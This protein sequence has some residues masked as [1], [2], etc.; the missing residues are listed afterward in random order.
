MFTSTDSGW[1]GWVLCGWF[2]VVGFAQTN[3]PSL[4][5]SFAVDFP[6]DSPV[7]FAS[8]NWEAIEVEPRA[9]MALLRVRATLSLK[10]TSNQSIRGIT[11][12][13]SSQEVTPGGKASISV[14]GL[15]VKPGDVFPVRIDLRLLQP[16]NG[17]VAP[18]V[19][20]GL[21]GVLFEHLAFYGPNLLNSRRR[22]IAWELEAER[23]R[24]YFRRVLREQGPEGLRRA[25]LASLSRQNRV[26]QASVR[27]S[28]VPV[29][30]TSQGEVLQLAV[31]QLPGAPVE[32]TGGSVHMTNARTMIPR[33]RVRNQSGRPVRYVEI[34]WFGR[35]PSGNPLV[36]G[37]LPGEL[38]LPRGASKELVGTASLQVLAGRRIETLTGFVRQVEFADGKLWIPAREE[39]EAAGLGGV[40]PSPEEQR[41]VELY[42]RQGLGAVIEWLEGTSRR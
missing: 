7:T 27:M 18:T 29:L 39:L 34:G 12:V 28:A 17:A 26:A 23:D 21:D 15:N 5:P 32:L 8:A 13:V 20:I 36:M 4:S 24:A 33:I 35:D 2:A 9:G 41:L 25:L 38:D 40:L 30:G 10:N 16:P 31:V 19:R 37:S 3:P 22:M 6:P 1:L 42:R 14:P 11:L